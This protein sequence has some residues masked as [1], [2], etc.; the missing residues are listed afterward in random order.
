MAPSPSSPETQAREAPRPLRW[1]RALVR[2]TGALAILALGAALVAWLQRDQIAGNLI[3]QALEENG[4]EA[5]YAIVAIGPRLQ[6]I[7]NLV[8]GDPQAPDFRARRI[9]IAIGYGWNGAFVERVTVAGA[10]L[11]GSYREGALSFGAL[12]PVLFGESEEDGGLPQVN[13][14]LVDAGARIETEY[15]LIGA[16]LSGEG[17]LSDGFKG[18]LALTAPDLGTAQC[19]ARALTAF[20]SL[21][22]TAG[23]PRFE[24]PLR[25][26]ELDCA[27]ARLAA[28]DIGSI[29]AVDAGFGSVEG[30]FVVEGQRL[31]ADEARL[32][33]FSGDVRL[34]LREAQLTVSHE[35]SGERLTSRYASLARIALEGRLRSSSDLAQADWSMSFAGEGIAAGPALDE[36]LAPL[37]DAGRET[38][39]A[40]LLA[41]FERGLAR[42]LTGARA[43]GEANWRLRAGEQAI[44]IPE[45]EIE[46][47]RG[48]RVLALSRASWSARGGGVPRLAG[49]FL[50]G[51]PDLPQI[52]GRMEQLAGGE[53]G[54]R[55]AMAPY[56]AG[57]AMLALPN[58]QLRQL[59][60]SEVRFAGQVRASGPIPGGSISALEVPLE[61]AI[62]PAGTLVIGRSCTT[63]RFAALALADLAL[64]R[65]SLV[66][67]PRTGSALVRYDD[68]LAIDASTG[69]LELTGAISGTRAVLKAEAAQLRYPGAFSLAGLSARL[70][71]GEAAVALSAQTLTGV[72]GDEIGGRYEQ[73][74]ARIGAV[75]LD[76]SGLNGSWTYVDGEARIRDATLRVSERTEGLP[77]F[78]PLEASDATL[79]LS[80]TAIRANAPLRH[81]R[82]RIPIAAV[83][84]R[85]DLADGTGEALL[86]VEGLTFGNGLALE[87]LSALTKGVVAYTEGTITGEG[88]IAWTPDDLTST[89]TFATQRL[90]FAAAFGPVRAVKG[91]I[92][93]SDLLGLTTEPDQVIE[94]GAINP[95]IEV[96][97]G[98]V[99]FAMREGTMIDVAGGRWPFMGGELVMRPVALRYG[100]GEEQRY[101]FEIIGLDAAKFVAQMEL[102][103]I[104]ATGTFDGTVRIAFDQNGDGRIEGGLLISRPPGGNV[105]YV[106]EL[107]YEDLGAIGNYAFQ[108]LRSLDYRQMSVELG[109]DLA[110]EIITRFTFDGV[111]QGTGASQNF[112]TR[113]LAGLPI[114]FRV[115]VRSE[116]FYELATM[117]RTFFDTSAL[118]N[119]L[120]QGLLGASGGRFVR[121]P[122]PGVPASPPDQP[123]EQSGDDPE[124]LRPDEPIVQ[125]PESEDRPS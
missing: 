11:F 57:S 21:T 54:L 64:D 85:H 117:V 33:A 47:V 108:S 91:T 95:G 23:A 8:I 2:L 111:R 105:S 78:E 87:D 62:S 72:L 34:G 123:P 61:G 100:E 6:V 81:P 15:G 90:D 14:R 73:G 41:R 20:G 46:S 49:N 69:P 27:G 28:G 16:S 56:R 7:E 22:T 115:N 104:G 70:G 5:R 101:T 116:N 92:A 74:E 102:G 76:F 125:P 9:S 94:I 65:R 12:D 29:V 45:A 13:L 80:D 79:T 107:S 1:R 121:P 109:G 71:E 58:L 10:R 26:R 77:R 122:P 31:E 106:G 86:R 17:D 113:R 59:A 97:A 30:E 24:G 67:C 110:G 4:L 82:T 114:R 98:R 55:L 93:F 52:N 44:V 66:L 124:A 3:D 18:L 39:T 84:V 118:P 35:L 48:E 40:P 43:S 53:L 50:V 119:P 112:I 89:G 19:S 103:N 60:S 51:G 75:P 88:R 25:V 38:L 96:L 32:A 37:R 99:V 120:D 68:A 83:S 36:A 42:A 63:I